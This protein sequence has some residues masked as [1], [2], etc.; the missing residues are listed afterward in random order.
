MTAKREWHKPMF[1]LL[2]VKETAADVNP[3][4]GQDLDAFIADPQGT[5]GGHEGGDLPETSENM[6]AFGQAHAQADLHS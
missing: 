5:L 1:Q 2:D 6:S 3:H 4:P